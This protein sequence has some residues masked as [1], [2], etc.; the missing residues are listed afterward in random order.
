MPPL[1]VPIV[2]LVASAANDLPVLGSLDRAR[3]RVR[4]RKLRGPTW[5]EP[6]AGD[7][8]PA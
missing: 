2:S 4:D 6:P 3:R 5:A 1:S 7:V 8:I